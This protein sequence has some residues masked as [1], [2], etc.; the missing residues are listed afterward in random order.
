MNDLVSIIIPTRNSG[1]LLENCLKSVS[2]QTYKNIEIIVVD[3]KSTDNTINLAKKYKCKLYLFV[4][5]VKKGVFDAS[6]KRNY[7]VKKSKGSYVYWLDADMELP[8][9]LIE[10]AVDLCKKGADAV[11]LPED[12]FGTGIWA[13]AKNLERRC[14][15]GDDTVECPRFLK[16]SI[17]NI[18]GGL[19]EFLGAGGDDLDIHQKVIEKGFKV[20]RTKNIV[21]HNEGNLKLSKLFKK[22]FM[23]GRDTIKYFYKRPRAS[24]VSYFPIRMAYLR[25]IKLFFSRPLDAFVFVFMRTI[26]YF[27]GFLGFLYSFINIDQINIRSGKKRIKVKK[28]NW[29]GIEE[30]ARILPQYYGTTI[31]KKLKKY[32]DATSFTSLLDCGCGDGALLYA[33]KQN[34]YFKNRKISAV[35]LSKNRID[36]VRKIDPKIHAYVDSAETLKRIKNN[37]ID[38]FMSTHV[39]EHVDDKKM[40][41][42]IDRVVRKN[43][44]IYIATIFKKWYGWY[45]YRKNGKWVMDLTHLR[46]Y[47]RDEELLNLIDKKKYIIIEMQKNQLYFPVIDFFIR[48]LFIKN[49]QLFVNNTFFNIIRNIKIPA[50]GYYNWEII[51]RKK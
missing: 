35:D 9:R 24:I 6:Y 2:K 14:Y 33:L 4:P 27:A 17:W 51:L 22:H 12:S 46:E 48:R 39:I 38:F 11:I 34:N 1:E 10:E 43:G 49:R 44:T 30:Y 20:G 41:D 32:L 5:K 7:G 45:Y 23:Y 25:N 42:A 28:N 50:V 36:L 40:L 29:G 26:E 15:W 3:G 47:S 31:P 16:H 13:R 19:D 18:I 8:K 21:M 37:S